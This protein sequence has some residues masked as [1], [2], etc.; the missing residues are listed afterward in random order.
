MDVQDPLRIRLMSHL[1]M[2]VAQRA[3]AVAGSNYYGATS[4]QSGWPTPASGYYGA[5]ADPTT[6]A[7]NGFEAG[8]PSTYMP[9]PIIPA[10]SAVSSS[11]TNSGTSTSTPVAS[12]ASAAS[13]TY[14]A[15]AH[16]QHYIPPAPIVHPSV[17]NTDDPSNTAANGNYSVNSK[18]Y[19]PWGTEMAC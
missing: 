14:M 5:P 1:Q 2:F 15:N 6:A 4:V 18:P 16:I 13:M 11:S 10:S 12:T 9:P 17:L 19:R 7:A 8:F 3:A